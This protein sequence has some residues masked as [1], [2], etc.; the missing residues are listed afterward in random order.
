M[1]LRATGNNTLR[2][3]L[4]SKPGTHLSVRIAGV[5]AVTDTTPPT[6]TAIVTSVPNAAGCNRTDVQVS[7]VCSD[8]GSGI[9]TCPLAQVV[10]SAGVNAP[11]PNR[12]V[13]M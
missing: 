9:A 12:R 11:A 1:A 7:F 4:R 5:A 6:I 10:S 13:T 2:I 8:A 3:E